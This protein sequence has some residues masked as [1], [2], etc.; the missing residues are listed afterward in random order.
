MKHHLLTD[1]KRR[2]RAPAPPPKVRWAVRLVVSLPLLAF[3]A[4]VVVYFAAL[5]HLLRA[6]LAP[7]A[8]N[9]VGRQIGHQVRLGSIEFQPGELILNNVAVSDRATFAGSGLG[10]VT[11]RIAIYYNL[12]DLLFDSGNAAHALGDIVIDRPTALAE[13][14]TQKTFNFSDVIDVFTKKPTRPHAKPFAGRIIV[15]NGTLHARD[16]VAPAN[17]GARPA[18]NTVADVNAT[19]DFHSLNN[20]YFTGTARGVDGRVTAV[21]LSGDASR[22]TAGRFRIAVKVADG[23]AAYWS[24][25]FAQASSVLKKATVVAGRAD[26]DLTVSRLESKP[27]PGLPIDL[28]GRVTVRGATVA[29]HDPRFRH[30]PLQSVNGFATFTGSGMTIDGSVL[31]GGQPVRVDG[32]VF[33]FTNPQL[34]FTASS[35]HL[36]AVRLARYFPQIPLPPGLGASPAPVTGQVTGSSLNPVVEIQTT[37]PA[38]TYRGNTATDVRMRVLYANSVFLFPDTTFRLNGG[39]QGAVRVTIDSVPKTPTVRIGGRVTGVNLAALRLPATPGR[40]LPALGGLANIA[41]LAD[42]EGKP[43]SIVANVSVDRPRIAKTTLRAARGRVVYSPAHGLTLSR[44]VVE[45]NNGGIATASG[46]IPLSASSPLALAVSA[47]GANLSRLLAPYS[48]VAVGGLAYAQAHVTG[49]L[50]APHVAGTVQLYGARY[51]RVAADM[52][53]GAVSGTTDAVRLQ[54]VVVR[55]Y[56]TAVHLSGTVSGLKSQNPQLALTASLSRGFLSN[57]VSLAKELAP[58][59]TQGGKSALSAVARLPELTGLVSGTVRVTGRLKSPQVAAHASVSDVLVDAYRIRAASADI[60]Y[61]NGTVRVANATV[62][63][64]DGATATARGQFTPKTGRLFAAFSGTHIDLDQ[65]DFLTQPYVTADGLLEVSGRVGG[66]LKSPFGTATVTAQDLT[67]EGQSLAPLTMAAHYADGVLTKT[68]APWDLTLLTPGAGGVRYI[69]DALR[70]TLPT[71][72][73]PNAPRTLSLAAQIPESSPENL[74][75]LISALRASRFHNTAAARRLLAQV[76]NLPATP[77]GVVWVPSLT[78]SGPFAAPSVQATVGARDLTVADNKIG[79]LDARLAYTGGANPSAHADITTG[80]I[81]AAGVPLQSVVAQADYANRVITVNRLDARSA[82][83]YLHGQGRANLDGAV[84]ASLDASDVPLSLFNLF[85]PA[86]ERLSGQISALTVV[87][88]GQT[89]SPD[90]TASVDLDQPAVTV[91]TPSTATQ[92]EMQIRYA[93]DSVRSS[94]I[95]LTAPATVGG[96]RLLTINDLSA[97]KGGRR[98]ATLSGTLPIAL[99]AALG[100]APTAV[101]G[102]LPDVP[103]SVPLHADLQ[104]ADLS[105]LAL[106]SPALVDPKRTGGT[107]SASVDYG[108]PGGTAAAPRL[109]G[110]VNIANASLGVIGFDTSLSALN[111]HVIV[112]NGHLTVPSFT[113]KS[114]KGGTL[115]LSGGGTL[116]LP[117][118][119]GRANL[120]LTASALRVDETGKGN[121]LAKNYNTGAKGQVDGA[122]TITGPWLSPLIATLPSAPLVVSNALGTLSTGATPVTTA[123]TVPP[124]DPRFNI[125]VLL[126]ARGKTISVRGPFLTAEAN[127]DLELT[128]RLSAP[129]LRAHVNVARGQFILPPT[130]RLAIVKPEDGTSNTVDVRYPAPLTDPTNANGPTLETRVHLVARANVSVSPATLAANQSVVGN[131]IGQSAPQTFSSS[132]DQTFGQQPNRYTITATITGLLNSTDPNEPQISLTSDPSGLNRQQMLAALVPEGALQGILGGGGGAQTAFKQGL[133]EAFSAVAV[134]A[135]LSPFEAGV[136]GALGLEDFSVDYAPNAPVNVTLTKQIAPR[137][138]VT[139]IRAIGARTPGAVNSVTSPPQYTLKLG[140]GLTRHLQVS[141]ST[142]DQKNN[143]IALESVF[144]F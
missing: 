61:A 34:A 121:F 119:T 66:T 16:Y 71:P 48:K 128:G 142:D 108:G 31:A 15:R 27:L 89:R 47:S 28:E 55:R 3:L 112:Q 138:L 59:P 99:P 102:L 50:S 23:D 10:A 113:A 62:R 8:A 104:I 4:V 53:T 132:L 118:A 130:T 81:L 70:V 39:G 85:L 73:H 133:Q 97:F 114:S 49:P 18:V 88:S 94:K 122:V 52:V 93:I 6:N 92:G 60:A 35:S 78:V 63:T 117:G 29:L 123:K 45:A 100:G 44:A 76:D 37:L 120:R 80:G 103:S 131:V 124:I 1:L 54:D 12:R 46:T 136:A 68:G 51:G 87:A 91:T 38:V 21:G 7:V 42:D 101:A 72:A 143:T 56:P 83:A 106:F 5:G 115:S 43:L 116:G 109:L 24:S 107:L 14:Y 64:D 134:P 13:R 135:L 2:S 125:A 139:Y 111:G 129:L 25:Y 57:V 127:G 67:I 141:V 32:S 84:S 22:Q 17:I 110:Q 75:H 96:V 9:E 41:F 140:Y 82:Q 105:V 19:V 126:G 11:P 95:T 79:S 86:K 30:L 40:K 137:L 90:L 58:T 33:D 74:T 20:V 98:L 144:N 77:E 26:L 65:Y 36:D 69:V